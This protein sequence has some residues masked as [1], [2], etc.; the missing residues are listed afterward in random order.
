MNLDKRVFRHLGKLLGPARHGR[1]S[2]G[3]TCQDWSG[4][5][6]QARHGSTTGWRGHH[7]GLVDKPRRRRNS[8]DSHPVTS[9]QA[10]WSVHSKGHSRTALQGTVSQEYLELNGVLGR[11]QSLAAQGV[12][13]S[14]GQ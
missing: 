6:H 10:V 11:E 9:Q 2:V 7:V 13:G 5:S 12:P 14:D 8:G 3:C 1:A 4:R